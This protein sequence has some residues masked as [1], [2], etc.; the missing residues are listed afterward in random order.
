[1]LYLCLIRATPP[2]YSFALSMP[3]HVLSVLEAAYLELNTDDPLQV[4][5]LTS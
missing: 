2:A 1:M 5:F 3:N 4:R